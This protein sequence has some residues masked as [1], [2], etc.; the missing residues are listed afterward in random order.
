MINYYGMDI[1]IASIINI[2]F[3]ANDYISSIVIAE[4]LG[5]SESTLFRLLPQLEE[6]TA[7]Y[8]LHFSKLRGRGFMLSGSEKA[9]ENLIADFAQK[10]YK[11][12][13]SPAEKSFLAFLHLLNEKDTVKLASLAN[14]LKISE[15][16]AAKIVSE[17]ET[18]LA[19]S[20]CEVIRKRG[21]G[22]CIGGNEIAVRLAALNSACLYVNF[23]ELMSLL[24]AY[25]HRSASERN[26]LKL[27]SFTSAVFEFFDAETTIKNNFDI[28]ET[29]ERS[30]GVSFSD[31]DFILMFLYI[32]ITELRRKNGF[33]IEPSADERTER[34]ESE[35]KIVQAV[36]DADFFIGGNPQCDNEIRVLTE[37]FQS[38]EAYNNI[39]PNQKEYERIAE[40][41]ITF[42]EGALDGRVAEQKRTA[43]IVYLQILHLIKRHKGLF[44]IQQN[45]SRLAENIVLKNNGM[46]KIVKPA[47]EYL[48]KRLHI[49][50]SEEDG[51]VMLGFIS[52]FFE[53]NTRKI[54]AG[55]VCASGL[56]V[57]SILKEKL[58]KAFPELDPIETI[59]IRKL[60]DAYVKEN[61]IDFII[62]FIETAP[63]AVPVAHISVRLEDSDIEQV[64]SILQNIR[65][66][67]ENAG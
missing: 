26:I 20:G 63:L 10:N 67:Y 36:S 7:P 24:Y 56:V 28:V 14:V 30:T 22:T 12:E 42:I 34:V 47:A 51:S 32:G 61:N 38:T 66:G 13:F 19:G 57:S 52:P 23:N 15:S 3:D 37:V 58:G 25:I 2:L 6:C 18:R 8:G 39:L 65:R 40:D 55:L 27:Y 1:R 9:K 29:V 59:S 4:K 41:F 49:P 48:Q 21:F 5:I 45:T 33:F 50:V 16:G 54:S 17:L 46:Q 53:R 64:K 11:P 44:S 62:S 31:I 60:T 35:A 43:Y